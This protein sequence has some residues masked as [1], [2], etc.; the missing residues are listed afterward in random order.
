MATRTELKLAE[1]EAEDYCCAPLA[2][3]EVTSEEASRAARL[4]K[5]LSDPTRVRIINLLA[6][7]GAPVCVCD[8]TSEVGL[9]QG[10]TSFHLK[11]LLDAGFLAREQRGTW[12]YY[13]LRR[14]VLERLADV[15]RTEGEMA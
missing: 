12:A 13:S 1:T 11:K 5:S 15:F 10:T 2:S 4:F 8:I 7:S 3:A 14:E 6:T 9:S